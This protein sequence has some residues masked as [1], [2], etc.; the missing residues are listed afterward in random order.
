VT[1]SLLEIQASVATWALGD[2]TGLSSKTL[3]RATCHLP[4]VSNPY[5][6]LDV[7]DFGR[8]YRLIQAVPEARIAVMELALLDQVWARLAGAWD[9]IAAAFEAE[10]A[11]GRVNRWG[12]RECPRTSELIKAATR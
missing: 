1:R 7:S 4:V 12:A 9:E 5:F 11:T 8:C 6:P 10:Q 3:A 2:D